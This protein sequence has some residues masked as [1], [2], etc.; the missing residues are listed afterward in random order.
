MIRKIAALV[1]GT[2]LATSL[3]GAGVGATFTKTSTAND[4]I[5]V[6]DL[7][8]SA[9]TSNDNAT[10]NGCSVTVTASSG[11]QDC[12]VRVDKSG[13][14]VPNNLQIVA[15]VSSGSI[16]E[17]NLWTVTDYLNV[18]GGINNL[19]PPTWNYANPV[20]SPWVAKYTVTWAGLTN[21][22]LNTTF[23]ITFTATASA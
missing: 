19:N 1:G 4:T 8:I 10:W 9:Y 5:T 18:T 20:F 13:A 16:P 14:I 23:V 22:S 7:A 17:W 15:T 11:T 12:Y 2:A 6:A 3:I 21:V